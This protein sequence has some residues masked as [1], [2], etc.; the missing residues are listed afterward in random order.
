MVVHVTHCTTP[1]NLLRVRKRPGVR[2]PL[3]WT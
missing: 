2:A 1:R 3:K